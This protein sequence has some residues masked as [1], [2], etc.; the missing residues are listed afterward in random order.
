MQGLLF[1][2]V[3]GAV[4]AGAFVNRAVG[5]LFP[6]VEGAVAVRTPIRSFPWAMA[7]SELTQAA[8]DF[9][10]QLGAAV[11]IVEIEEIARGAAMFATTTGG[12]SMSTAAF[13]GCQR[14]SVGALV[15]GAQLLPVQGRRGSRR[16][17]QGSLGVDREIAVVRMLLTKIIAGWDLGLRISK[18][19]SKLANQLF[20]FRASKFSAQ[21][22]DKACYFAHDGESPGNLPVPYRVVLERETPPSFSF[23][24]KPRGWNPR[25]K[26]PAV[27]TDARWKPWK[28]PR[29]IF[30]PFPPRLENSPQKALRVSPS[31]HSSA[32]SSSTKPKSK[33][34]HTFIVELS[35]RRGEKA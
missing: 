1:L 28:N 3:V 22:K 26:L 33:K 2:E 8:T 25:S 10:A 4:V 35:R 32:A 20:Q 14:P 18:K 6:A 16:L 31:S 27:E 19:F 29:T 9:A 21:P 23:S 24:V 5:T 12:E 34:P 13:H 30:P 17:S 7:P 11:P 15:V